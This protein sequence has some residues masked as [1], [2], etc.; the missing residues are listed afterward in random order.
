MK[1]AQAGTLVAKLGEYKGLRLFRKHCYRLRYV[2]VASTLGFQVQD[3]VIWGALP[4]V[5]AAWVRPIAHA[6]RQI[7]RLGAPAGGDIHEVFH[8]PVLGRIPA[9]TREVE[10]SPLGVHEWRV[11]QVQITAA[12]QDMN[13]GLGLAVGGGDDDPRQRVRQLLGKPCHLVPPG[14]DV[15]RPG[16]LLEEWGR[17]AE[18]RRRHMGVETV[19]QRENVHGGLPRRWS[20]VEVV[21]DDT[22]PIALRW[23]PFQVH[24]FWRRYCLNN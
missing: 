15:S 3:A 5:S 16:G 11:G 23:Q 20:R 14:L 19:E 13:A 10:P 21:A 12:Q 8:A 17:D 2:R 6:Q 18:G 4:S 24:E 22:S 7:G 1:T 9:V